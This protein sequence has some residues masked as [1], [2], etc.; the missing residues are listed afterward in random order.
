MSNLKFKPIFN[1]KTLQCL[2]WL[3]IKQLH[4][5]KYIDFYVYFKIQI[6]NLQYQDLGI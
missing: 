2:Q 3:R 5:D 4:I 6:K 1:D